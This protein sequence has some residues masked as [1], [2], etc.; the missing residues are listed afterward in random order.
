[1]GAAKISIEQVQ[2]QEEKADT[3]KALKKQQQSAKKEYAS[4]L[5]RCQEI[6][7]KQQTSHPRFAECNK[8]IASSL[9]EIREFSATGTKGTIAGSGTG[10]AA[11]NAP[12]A[13]SGTA[14][15]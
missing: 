10:A 9:L 15:K 5:K 1:M 2:K 11:S 12:S 3:L 8:M 4:Q 6:S 7:A 13:A 14:K